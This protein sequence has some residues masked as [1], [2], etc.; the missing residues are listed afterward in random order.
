MVR[1]FKEDEH[2]RYEINLE[3]TKASNVQ[4][5]ARLLTLAKINHKSKS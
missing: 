4:I 5:E 1:F 2:I 3:S